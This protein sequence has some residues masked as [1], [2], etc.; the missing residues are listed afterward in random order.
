M[1]RFNNTK[2][3]GKPAL[4]YGFIAYP[5][6]V[7]IAFALP[8][9]LLSALLRGVW[10]ADL[11]TANALCAL[12]VCIYH[13]RYKRK[14]LPS[15]EKIDYKRLFVMSFLMLSSMAFL[16][17][18]LAGRA[19]KGLNA[20]SL[21][22]AVFWNFF[23]I[24]FMEELI[25]REYLAKKMEAAGMHPG[26]MILISSVL[27]S[28]CHRPDSAGLFLERAVLGALLFLLYFRSRDLP[29]CV[30][31]HWAYNALIHTFRLALPA[32]CD[33]YSLTRAGFT[34]FLCLII[35]LGIIIVY[36]PNKSKFAR[37]SKR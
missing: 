25:F 32:V 27:F 3:A 21:C 31:A 17:G 20:G 19:L 11:L 34:G 16:W 26:I 15:I 9:L 22:L 33:Y 36:Y 1:W 24:A 2:R 35:L 8:S 13:L 7:Y 12:G 10:H 37:H 28:L 6:L 4:S 18:L 5:V 30:A 29:L 23:W 14:K